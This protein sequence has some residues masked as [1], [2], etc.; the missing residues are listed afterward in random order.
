MKMLKWYLP[1]IMRGF[2]HA[3]LSYFLFSYSSSSLSVSSLLF[4]AVILFISPLCS[5]NLSFWLNNPFIPFYTLSMFFFTIFKH[6]VADLTITVCTTT[7]TLPPPFPSVAPALRPLSL[8]TLLGWGGPRQTYGPLWHGVAILFLL[9]T[10][11]LHWGGETRWRF[12]L[13]PPDPPHSVQTPC[14][15][16]GPATRILTRAGSL[17]LIHFHLIQFN[18]ILTVHI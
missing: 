1:L 17:H 12:T 6:L 18:P 7:V 3:P 11:G 2:P 13:S 10:G 8:Q 9:C 16:N 14:L 15:S 4:S 5:L